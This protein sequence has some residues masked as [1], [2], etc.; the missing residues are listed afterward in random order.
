MYTFTF[1]LEAADELKALAEEI[2]EHDRR[3]YQD[4]APAVSDAAYDALRRR[5]EAIESLFPNLVR[6]DSPTRR[7]GA[8]P[9][10]GFGKVR[11][12]RPMLSLGNAF[13]EEDVAERFNG[14]S[15]AGFLA[16]PF[17]ARSLRAMIRKAFEEVPA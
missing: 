4:N 10:A 6:P 2:S 17:S 11:H 3:Y 5:N 15:V 9:A 7:V 12:A 8:A 1:P 16:K 14:A 13:T